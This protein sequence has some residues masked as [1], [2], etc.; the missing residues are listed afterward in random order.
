MR[1]SYH[2]DTDSLYIHLNE[3][4]TSESEEVA[5]DTVLHF[6]ENGE[7]TGFEI[8]SE[9]GHRVDLSELEIAGLDEQLFAARVSQISD[10]SAAAALRYALGVAG[11]VPT[12]E[13]GEIF[14]NDT[15]YVGI[16]GRLMRED[17]ILLR[18]AAR[19]RFDE[20]R[21]KRAIGIVGDREAV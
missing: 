19:W 12:F 7:V 21:L 1:I 11:G 13:P 5:P 3:R 14:V 6:D 2:K 18:G 8:Y 15:A 4:R 16:P 20:G 9:A 17:D 10:A